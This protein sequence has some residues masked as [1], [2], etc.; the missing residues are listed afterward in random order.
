MRIRSAENIR[1]IDDPFHRGETRWLAN[2][3]QVFRAAGYEIHSTDPELIIG[4]PWEN[5]SHFKDILHIHLRFGLLTEACLPHLK[6][7]GDNCRVAAPYEESIQR[8]PDLAPHVIFMPIPYLEKWLP[9]ER[10]DPLQRREI[11]WAAKEIWHRELGQRSPSIPQCG[12]WMLEAIRN[13]TRERDL[14]LNI[15]QCAEEGSH[16]DTAPQVAKDIL[17]EIPNVNIL[18]GSQPLSTLIEIFSRS[19][20]SLPIG[21]ALG[22]T[23]EAVFAGCIP[24]AHKGTALG[25]QA[26]IKGFNLPPVGQCTKEDIQTGLQKMFDDD[27]YQQVWDCYQ[28]EIQPHLAQNAIEIFEGQL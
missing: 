2:W 3:V 24:L 18:N 22:S 1:N 28:K 19:R 25:R 23:I 16:F 13:L 26:E 9:Q 21:G 27:Y 15:I 20:L 14:T 17:A 6:C 4:V 8:R 10:I 12:I 5:N 7:F 11:T